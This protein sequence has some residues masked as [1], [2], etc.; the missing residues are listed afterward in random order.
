MLTQD[1]KSWK[2]CCNLIK[3]HNFINVTFFGF[4]PLVDIV[5]KNIPLLIGNIFG[6][7]KGILHNQNEHSGGVNSFTAAANVT[8][9]GH[10]LGH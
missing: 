2:V 10:A 6:N 7:S 9:K 1:F 5:A 3:L 8:A 4:P